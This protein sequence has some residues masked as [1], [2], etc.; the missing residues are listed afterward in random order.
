[1][2]ILYPDYNAGGKK[3]KKGQEGFRLN[4]PL[5]GQRNPLEIVFFD[6]VAEIPETG[7]DTLMSKMV[8]VSD[9][10]S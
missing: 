3:I 6:E 8:K 10:T 1:M 5:K 7:W 9:K 4:V 2:A